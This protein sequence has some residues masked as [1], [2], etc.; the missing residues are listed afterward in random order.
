MRRKINASFKVSKGSLISL[1]LANAAGDLKLELVLI[2]YSKNLTDFKNYAKSTLSVLYKLNNKAWLQ[3]SV[4]KTFP[5]YFKPT[6][7]AHCSGKT[8]QN[9]QKKIPLL[10]F[11]LFS[12][13][14]LDPGTMMEMYDELNIF[15]PANTASILQL[16]GQRK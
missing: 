13:N 2:Y 12:V 7:K 5:K 14:A 3:H 10:Y 9:K 1:L 15:M 4:Y 8:K 11:C 6:V 16:M